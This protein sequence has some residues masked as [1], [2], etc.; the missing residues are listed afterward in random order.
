MILDIVVKWLVSIA[1]SQSLGDIFKNMGS[2]DIPHTESESL[3]MGQ[4]GVQTRD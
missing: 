2:W 3:G 4:Q 1:L